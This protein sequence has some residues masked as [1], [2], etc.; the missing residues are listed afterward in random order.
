MNQ[1]EQWNRDGVILL[2]MSEVAQSEAATGGNSAR[3]SKAAIYIASSSLI[4]TRE[5]VAK[6][7]AFSRIL[8]G[9][10][11]RTSAQEND[12]I[13]VFNAWKYGRLLVTAD[14]ESKAHPGGILGNRTAL[15]AEG[16][17]A[18]TDREAVRRVRA[19]IA[20]RDE[21]ARLKHVESGEPL[22]QWV[23]RD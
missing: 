10:A 2:S 16:V 1:L 13:I 5:E 7:A 22:P 12:A 15:L 19:R 14:G 8:S 9:P 20:T 21:M 6:L 4:T 18:I 11:Q 17:E 23:G 3:E